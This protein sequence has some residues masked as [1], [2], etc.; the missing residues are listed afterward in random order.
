MKDLQE[1]LR[2]I[3]EAASTVL[4]ASSEHQLI[5]PDHHLDTLADALRDVCYVLRELTADKQDAEE[6]INSITD[7]WSAHYV[8]PTLK[9]CSLCGN[10]G[11]LDTTNSAISPTGAYAGLRNFC[12][13]P[14]GQKMRE[15]SKK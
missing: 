12:I 8:H 4:S 5:N 9:I 13:C 11:T 15:F 6:E 10:T 7:Y 14:N 2:R 3:E 1:E